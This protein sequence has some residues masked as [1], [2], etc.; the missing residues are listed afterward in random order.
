MPGALPVLNRKAVEYAIKAGLSVGCSINEY[1]VFER[2]NYFYPDLAKAYQISQL[3]YPLCVGGGVSI[4]RQWKLEQGKRLGKPMYFTNEKST[5]NKEEL[6]SILKEYDVAC[7]VTSEAPTFVPPDMDS[8]KSSKWAN[9][10][11]GVV[12]DVI[13]QRLVMDS[14]YNEFMLNDKKPYIWA[15]ASSVNNAITI[16]NIRFISISLGN[17]LINAQEVVEEVFGFHLGKNDHSGKTKKTLEKSPWM[18]EVEKRRADIHLANHNDEEN[19][20]ATV[21]IDGGAALGEFENPYA[22]QVLRDNI[23]QIDARIVEDIYRYGA[24]EAQ[25]NVNPIMF[26]AINEYAPAPMYAPAQ[27]ETFPIDSAETT[28]AAN[29]TNVVNE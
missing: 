3:E 15:Y 27:W 19:D 24:R 1:S 2:K 11:K 22:T 26:N 4:D 29:T 10:D 17:R 14:I 25:T 20:D 8:I 12:K 7:V 6:E 16:N 9:L 28:V 13:T 23:A 18:Q 21:E 5:F